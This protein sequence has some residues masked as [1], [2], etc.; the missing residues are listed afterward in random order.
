M[1][2]YAEVNV[3]G[4]V[5]NMLVWDGATTFNVAPNTL[6]SASGQPNAQIGGTYLGGVFTAPAVPTAPP[7]IMFLN[8]PASGAVLALPAAVQSGGAGYA[9]QYVD[10]TPAAALAALTLQLPVSP[11]DGD[12]LYVQSSK[13]ITAL[14]V[15]PGPGQSLLNFNSPIA[16]AAGVS[17]HIT[18]SAQL[19][20]WFHL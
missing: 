18:Y 16:L 7:G 5:V 3:S 19:G 4:S 15:T 12:E 20:G 9:K 8:S 2:L 11:G 17:Q 1:G 13:A 14:T 10:L 6:V